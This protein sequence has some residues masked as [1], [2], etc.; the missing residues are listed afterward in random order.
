MTTQTKSSSGQFGSVK[1]GLIKITRV[2]HPPLF[3]M[4]TVCLREN[5][6][7]KFVALQ[8]QLYRTSILDADN[9]S[10]TKSPDS[11]PEN[12]KGTMPT[13]ITVRSKSVSSCLFLHKQKN[14]KCDRETGRPVRRICE[15]SSLSWRISDNFLVQ[16]IFFFLHP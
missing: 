12:I 1:V 10:R 5:T 8:P 2:R 6:G 14:H 16:T 4:E 9:V 3:A 13:Q 11:E 7:A 15:S